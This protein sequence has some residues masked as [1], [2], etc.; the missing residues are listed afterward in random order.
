MRLA[1][2][3]DKCRLH[4]RSCLAM[5]RRP[6]LIT[7]AIVDKRL[8]TLPSLHVQRVFLFFL[9]SLRFVASLVLQLIF[10][11]HQP[12]PFSI[13]NTNST[14]QLSQSQKKKKQPSKTHQSNPYRNKM[15]SPHHVVC[16]RTNKE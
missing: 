12:L 4:I 13:F 8:I 5:F 1:L 3:Y 10:F 2:N 9:F 15:T 7:T 6:Y 11:V 14:Q 16:Y